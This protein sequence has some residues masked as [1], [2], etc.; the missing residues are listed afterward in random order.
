MDIEILCKL[1]DDSCMSSFL[2]MIVVINF[3]VIP[4]VL[5]FDDDF[6]SCIDPMTDK[7]VKNFKYLYT[8]VN[9]IVMRCRPEHADIR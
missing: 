5:S 4:A 1:N 2:S 8:E 9:E 7:L 6:F 3:L